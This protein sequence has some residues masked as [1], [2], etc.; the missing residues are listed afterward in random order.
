MFL[1]LKENTPVSLI[2]EIRAK[3]I[4]K[5]IKFYKSVYLSPTYRQTFMIMMQVI[6]F[7]K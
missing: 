2:W 1:T 5:I 7:R 6:N 3:Q 4:N